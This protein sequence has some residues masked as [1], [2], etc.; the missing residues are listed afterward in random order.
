M[1]NDKKHARELRKL[2]WRVITVWECQLKKPDR[3]LHQLENLFAAKE[4]IERK[5]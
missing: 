2:D 1:A 5:S 4:R 3:V